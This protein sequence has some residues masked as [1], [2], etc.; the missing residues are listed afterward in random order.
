M[1]AEL[2]RSDER[3]THVGHH[4]VEWSWEDERQGH[5]ADTVS[6]TRQQIRCGVLVVTIVL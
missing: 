2:T 6:Q 4:C 1:G 5:G 3:S